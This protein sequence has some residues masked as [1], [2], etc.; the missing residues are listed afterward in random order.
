[1]PFRSID[2]IRTTFHRTVPYR[3]FIIVLFAG[4]AMIN[5]W[6]IGLWTTRRS[7]GLCSTSAWPET[8]QDGR[9]CD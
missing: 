5:L 3:L 8:N 1:M 4:P 6:I 7:V 2:C 9:G